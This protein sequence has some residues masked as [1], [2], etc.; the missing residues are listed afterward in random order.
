MFPCPFSARGAIYRGSN[1]GH[2]GHSARGAIYR[3][4]N[5]GYTG[6]KPCNQNVTYPLAQNPKPAWSFCYKLQVT[7]TTRQ[8][9]K[10]ATTTTTTTHPHQLPSTP[11]NLC[12]QPIFAYFTGEIAD[13]RLQIWLHLGYAWLQSPILPLT[14]AGAFIKPCQ[15]TPEGV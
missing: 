5:R 8:N 4:S 12:N 2:E 9:L 10:T 14:T 13:F 3:G 6:Y 11:C 1:L 15:Y 7:Q